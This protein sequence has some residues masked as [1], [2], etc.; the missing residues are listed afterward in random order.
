[1][2]NVGYPWFRCGLPELAARL[3]ARLADLA[4]GQGDLVTHSLGGI[5][6]RWVLACEPETWQRTHALGHV[7]M[8]ALPNHRSA[9]ARMHQVGRGA[10]PR[11]SAVRRDA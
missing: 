11:S 10:S 1:M 7:V 2:A 6:L 9:T 5:L 4:A 8:L 3:D